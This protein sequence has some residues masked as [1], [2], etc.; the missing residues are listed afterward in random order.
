MRLATRALL[1]G[2]L[3][4]ALAELQQG[5]DSSG[6]CRFAAGLAERK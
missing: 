4:G 1:N 6:R 5:I 3:A 2:D